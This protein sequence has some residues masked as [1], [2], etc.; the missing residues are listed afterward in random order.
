MGAPSGPTPESDGA[1][2]S[3]RHVLQIKTNIEGL[4]YIIERPARRAG[5]TSALPRL[6]L[7]ETTP[8]PH[9]LRGFDWLV[10]AYLSGLPGVL[11]ADDMGLGKTF[12]ALLFL[13]WIRSNELALGR[14]EPP[15]KRPILIVAPTALL[16]NWGAEAA[17]HL[18]RG[19]LGERL[20][21]FAGGLARLKMGKGRAGETLDYDAL[22]AADL[23]LTTYETLATH[24][25]SFARVH[26]STIVFDEMQK[27][28]SPKTI[29]SQ[30]AKAMNGDF[31][32]GLTGTPIENRIEDLWC[33]MDRVA[34]GYLGDLKSFSTKYGGE[35]PQALKELKVKIDQPTP[36]QP[37]LMLRRMK[38]DILVGLPKKKIMTY[39]T[40][41]PQQ[42][43]DAYQEAVREA[44]S[45]AG[46]RNGMLAA[47]HRLRG[48]SLHPTE[49]TGLDPFD[50]KSA[51]KWVSASARLLKADEIL[52][53]VKSR[54][55][56]AIVFVEYHAMM[57]AFA[58]VAPLL[59]G[60]KRPAI[61]NGETPGPSRQEIVDRFQ[62]GPEGFDMLVL[63]PRAAGVG[64]TITAAN[65]V[66][67]LSRWWN[68]AVEDQCN[69]RVYRIGQEREVTIH[70]PLA[71]HPIFGDSSFDHTLDNLLAIKRS[72]SRDMLA[73][74][75]QGN[76][77]EKMFGATFDGKSL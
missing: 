36:P 16:A 44:K 61:I 20:D 37:A 8:K 66:V 55:E 76:D 71:R 7:S 34:P 26:F 32:L 52:R 69:D 48:V 28:K 68:P 19:A 54:G 65:H 5:V 1:T 9:Q 39:Q 49:A 60:V 41:M 57:E 15:A 59:F 50:E 33:V 11:L 22:R 6:A 3:A 12:Q 18:A 14:K 2:S 17:R 4:D 25:R 10:E 13:A 31:I 67:H 35:D 23:I 75:V 73:P 51:S 64:L 45:G 77:I 53:Q 43:A 63:S 74:P 29:N 30:T 27:I 40:M 38:D 46:D 72:L 70:I 58:D 42:Q 62:A 21:A 47:L 24:H 56:K